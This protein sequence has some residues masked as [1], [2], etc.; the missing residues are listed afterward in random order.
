MCSGVLKQELVVL[1][2]QLVVLKQELVVLSLVRPE[3]D[4]RV[5]V[6]SECVDL[7]QDL[8]DLQVRP[9]QP[10]L[11]AQS[12]AIR[13]LFSLVVTRRCEISCKAIDCHHPWLPDG[14]DGTAAE[15]EK[16]KRLV[17]LTA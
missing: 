5:I 9:C 6:P 3:Q 15:A 2:Q 12:T 8:A 10:A 7:V 17:V 14:N 4:E 16:A 13:E 1:K 11:A